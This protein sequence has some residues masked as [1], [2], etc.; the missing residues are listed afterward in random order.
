MTCKHYSYDLIETDRHYVH[1]PY[2]NN[3]VLCT[4]EKE[5]RMTQ[6]EIANVLGLSKMRICY[7]EKEAIRKLHKKLKRFLL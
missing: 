6:E 7:I 3:C 1:F 4:A 2:Y 5:G